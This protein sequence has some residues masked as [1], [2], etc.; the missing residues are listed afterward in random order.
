MTQYLPPNLLAL[1]APRDPI[2]YCAPLD[3]LPWDKKPWPYTGIAQYV[4]LFEEASETPP[5]TRAETKDERAARKQQERTER[6]SAAL[7]AQVD[8]WDLPNDPN[9]EGDPFK[10][11]FVGRINFDT[12]ESKLRREFEQ[13]GHIKAIKVMVN[14]QTEK[15]RGYAFIEYDKERDMHSAYKNAD[16]KKIDGKRVVVDVERGRTV[17]SWRPRRLGGGLGGTRRGGPNENIKY[18]G[19]VDERDVGG[20]DRSTRSRDRGDRE[21]LRSQSR[22]QSRDDR[23]RRSRS[24]EKPRRDRSRSQERR[25]SDKRDRPNR[26]RSDRDRPDR[27]RSDR[28]R[29]DRNREKSDRPDRDRSDRDKPNR[30]RSDRDRS[31]KPDRDRSDK[32]DR[33]RSDRDRSD[34][35]RSSRRDKDR[36]RDRD[37]KD[38]ERS[39]DRKREREEKDGEERKRMKVDPDPP[40]SNGSEGTSEGLI[41]TES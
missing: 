5:A 8:K 35:D 7:K 21:K 39:K 4:G 2:P 11:L 9:V 31:D 32:S 16:G 27:D 36:D 15:P 24:R 34:R 10:T 19:R 12:S 38:K 1:F 29:P 26:N 20:D 41:K 3:V 14:N 33:D 30:D 40:R 23:R 25:D 13:Y 22:D 18:S 17:K 6:Q 37:S 28:S